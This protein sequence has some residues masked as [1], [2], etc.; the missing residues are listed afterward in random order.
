MQVLLPDNFQTGRR[1]RVL[2]LLSVD[3]GDNLQFGNPMAEARRQGFH[4]RYDLI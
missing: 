1:Y 2:Y 3:A 4:N